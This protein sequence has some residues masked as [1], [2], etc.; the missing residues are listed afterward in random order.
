MN[1]AN[2]HEC[3][4]EYCVSQNMVTD[5]DNIMG[6]LSNEQ[7]FVCT[8][9]LSTSLHKLVLIFRSKSHHGRWYAKVLLESH[10]VLDNGYWVDLAKIICIGKRSCTSL[11]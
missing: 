5:L 1:V 11:K 8:S 4:V 9:D 3:S 6:M 7:R 10:D 2:I